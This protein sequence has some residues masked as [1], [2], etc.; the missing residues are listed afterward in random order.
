MANTPSRA[1]LAGGSLLAL[2]LIAGTV[3]GA[4]RGQPS[5]GFVAGLGVGL[6]LIALIWLVDRARG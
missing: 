6:A 1:P 3:L 5:M 4:L 2:S